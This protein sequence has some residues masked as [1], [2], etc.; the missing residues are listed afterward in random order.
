ML[1]TGAEDAMF[2]VCAAAV[3]AST[4]DSS[5]PPIIR[6]MRPAPWFQIE[7]SG[8]MRASARLGG[9]G[10]DPYTALG[11]VGAGCFIISYFG[12]LQGWLAP[13]GWPLPAINL[14]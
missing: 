11:I 3:P 10:I 5:S 14:A 9:M 7:Y 8:P 2:S 4:A 12:T 6:I 1:V 13:D